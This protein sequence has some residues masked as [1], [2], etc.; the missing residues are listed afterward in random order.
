MDERRRV[1]PFSRRQFLTGAATLAGS[2]LLAACGSGKGETGGQ[3][4][5]APKPAGTTAPATG[6]TTVPAAGSSAAPTTAA[7]AGAT[8]QPDLT[9][10]SGKFN[11]WFSANW[12]TVTDEAVGNVFVDWGKKNN[13]TVQ[14]QSIPGSPIILQKESAALAAGQPPEIDNNNLVYWYTQG[15]MGNLTDLVNKFKGMAGGMFPIGISSL[16]AP[17][18]G[19]FATP[20]AIDVW[21]AHW[22]TDIIGAKNNGKFFDTYDQLIE[23]GPQVQSPPKNY[24][25]AMALGHEGDHVNNI[26]TALW[27]YGGRLN[28]EKGVPDITNP[29]NKAAIQIIANMWK[30][31]LIPPE[32]FAQTVTSWNNETYQKSR[33]LMA[34]NPATIMGWLL[35]ND[36]ELGN[37]TGLA[38]PP[39]GP[40]GQFAEGSAIGFGYFKK[41]K[42]AEQSLKALDFFMAPE[43]LLKISKSVEGRFVPVYQDHAKGDFWEKSKFA[44]LKNI[45]TVGRVR[46][47]PAP[48]QPWLT[49]VTDAKYVLSD[50]MN[51][52]LNQN[53]AIEDAQAAAQ[54]D[55]MDSYNKFVKK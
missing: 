2:A 53:M 46:N 48:P 1:G 12:N 28:D 18:G 4:T 14:W 44:E 22:R 49:D 32:T 31:K 19:V 20:Y 52:I 11:V 6:A 38:T 47:W 45:A 29:A 37:N 41:A 10:V 8:P 34:V 3:A 7:A 5:T 51:K 36:K 9:I 54:K 15:E 40:A 42:L 21:P 50:M 24:T 39:K 30:A 13:V 55:M 43:N 33:G 26:V 16:T 35:V 27:A 23:L 25:Y 17:D